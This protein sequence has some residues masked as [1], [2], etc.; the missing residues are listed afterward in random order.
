MRSR[1]VQLEATSGALGR[2]LCKDS[3]KCSVHVTD[4]HAAKL[5]QPPPPWAPTTLHDLWCS[6]LAVGSQHTAYVRHEPWQEGMCQCTAVLLQSCAAQLERA[7]SPKRLHARACICG[8]CDRL[9]VLHMYCCCSKSLCHPCSLAEAHG[10]GFR[11]FAMTG[12]CHM[13][14]LSQPSY[15]I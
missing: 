12:P 2:A 7:G 11:G 8:V 10:H 5:S 6:S 4:A 3:R 9:I 1:A 15:S 13:C 14:G